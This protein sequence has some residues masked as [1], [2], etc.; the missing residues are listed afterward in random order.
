MAKLDNFMD[1]IIRAIPVW[2]EVLKKPTP[3][4][5]MLA[6]AGGAAGAIAVT[7]IKAG[8]QLCGVLHYTAATSLAD[9]SAE[10]I[11]NTDAGQI[12]QSDG[13]INNTGGTATTGDV[14][15]VV[16]LSWMA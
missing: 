12:I 6:V 1:R 3:F 5:R 4:V 13:E 8:D 2:K 9:I 15:V 11:L 14:L 16:W 7:G 10:F